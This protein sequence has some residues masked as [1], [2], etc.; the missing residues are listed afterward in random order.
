ML[1]RTMCQ[2]SGLSASTSAGFSCRLTDRVGLA[3]DAYYALLT[4][5]RF[6]GARRTVDA[7]VDAGAL[8]V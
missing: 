1:D 5:R 7:L 6:A 2:A 4:V 3:M 8:L